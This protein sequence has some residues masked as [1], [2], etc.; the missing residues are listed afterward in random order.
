MSDEPKTAHRLYQCEPVTTSAGT[1]YRLRLIED[2][3]EV[4]QGLVSP[5]EAEEVGARWIKDPNLVPYNSFTLTPAGISRYP[6]H[7]SVA[8]GLKLYKVARRSKESQHRHGRK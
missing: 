3:E 5:L 4:A 2:G 6:S 7:P 1:A 8:R